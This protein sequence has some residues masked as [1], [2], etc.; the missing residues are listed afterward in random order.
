MVGAD[1]RGSSLEVGYLELTL[2]Y[3]RELSAWHDICYLKVEHTLEP[4]LPYY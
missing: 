1:L 3:L 2:L 4:G